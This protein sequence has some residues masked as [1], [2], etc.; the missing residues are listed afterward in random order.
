[1]DEECYELALSRWK[2]IHTEYMGFAYFLEP[3]A[4]GGMN[5]YGND[6]NVTMHQLKVYILNHKEVLSLDANLDAE[7]VVSEIS[8]LVDCVVNVT[9]VDKENIIN[10]PGKVWWNT[11]D[12]ETFPILFKVASR[13]F[14][15]YT[16]FA[17]IVCVSGLCMIAYIPSD[18]IV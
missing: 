3:N 8:S 12:R 15:F 9:G 7:A 5:M 11:I 16:S 6:K 17:A 2:F 14:V 13:L 18:E 1:M 10:Y 4:C